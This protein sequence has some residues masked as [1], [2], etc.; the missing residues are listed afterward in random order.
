MKTYLNHNYN[1]KNFT[2]SVYYR[3]CSN[4]QYQFKS[5]QVAQELLKALSNAKVGTTT[6]EQIEIAVIPL[7]GV[8]N[9]D[10]KACFI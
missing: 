9:I 1:K 6:Y 8:S 10:P 4:K 7:F 3:P 5:D 2:V